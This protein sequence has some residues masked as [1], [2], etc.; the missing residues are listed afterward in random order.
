MNLTLRAV[1][2]NH[3]PL[4]QPLS[5]DFDA[6]GGSVGR[7]EH[8]TLALH[9]PERHISRRHAEISASGGGFA[10]RNVGSSNPILVQGKSLAHGESAL[11]AHRDQ[12]RLGGYVLEVICEPLD[13][14]TT[15]IRGRAVVSAP[16]ASAG[17]AGS[18]GSVGAA[19][20]SAPLSSSNP[21]ADLLGDAAPLANSKPSTPV[22]PAAP[23][24]P[25]TPAAPNAPAPQPA[26]VTLPDDFDPFA[27]FAPPEPKPV[28]A[29][30]MGSGTFDDLIPSA[31]P[32]SI[33]QFFGLQPGERDLLADFMADVAAPRSNAAAGGALPSTDPMAMFGDFA[34]DR[35]ESA[36]PPA[37]HVPELRAA[38]TPP[39][40]AAPSVAVLPSAAVLAPLATPQAA[41][42]ATPVSAPAPAPA[43]APAGDAWQGSPRELWAAFCDGAGVTIEPEGVNPEQM[44]V[45]G[46]LLQA[47]VAGTLQLMAV[48]ASAKRELRA[49]VTVIQSGNN[50]PL[51]FSPDVQS[52][53]EQILQ[54]PMRGFLAGP[55]AM[56]DAM[57]DLVGHTI[58]T[59]AGTRAALEGVLDRFTPQQLEAKLTTHTLLDSV[60]PTTRK[61]RLWAL[62]L[63]HFEAI[64]NEAQDDFHAL[65]GRAFLAAYE[66][67]IERLQRDEPGPG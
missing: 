57:H 22:T 9:D 43:P 6:Q 37:D 48:R 33:D 17:S 3:Q 47:S 42:E 44:R 2:L 16:M 19:D 27:A 5:A 31:A 46:K 66:Q 29:A 20:L 13:E 30:P 11:L 60:L 41:P 62:Y 39:L 59:M 14:A 54:P 8:N 52:A 65:F 18:A 32:P 58:G 50:N 7:S 51:K 28:A 35:A 4:P 63:Q 45:I 24:T 55:A 49:E 53:L 56:T 21:F 15:V 1:S 26:R 10:I 67:Q 34:P 23:S 25:T 40:A 12:V 61:A 64:R 38:F 36:A